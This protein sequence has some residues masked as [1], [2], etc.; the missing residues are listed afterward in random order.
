MTFTLQMIMLV[1]IDPCSLEICMA[2]RTCSWIMIPSLHP[3]AKFSHSIHSSHG[4]TDRITFQLVTT[5]MISSMNP[6]VD[7]IVGNVNVFNKLYV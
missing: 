7:F 1:V 3:T 4:A 5:C 6:Y 2:L